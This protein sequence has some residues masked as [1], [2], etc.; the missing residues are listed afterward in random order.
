MALQQQGV[1]LIEKLND[2]RNQDKF[3]WRETAGG[4]TFVVTLARFELVLSKF[5]GDC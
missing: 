4:D 5:P 3:A 1:K 2:P